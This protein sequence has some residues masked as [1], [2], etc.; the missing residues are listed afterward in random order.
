MKCNKCGIEMMRVR[1]DGGKAVYVCR[2]PKCSEHGKEQGH[3]S[4]VKE[5][6]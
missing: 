5:N 6:Q 2:N 3:E 1:V 4:A